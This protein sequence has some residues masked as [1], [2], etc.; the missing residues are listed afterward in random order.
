MAAM[1]A[2]QAGH[3]YGPAAPIWVRS[4]A[5]LAE[6]IVGEQLNLLLGSKP[7]PETSEGSDW[8]KFRL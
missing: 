8:V 4:R 6:G 3:Q 5:R 7:R 1:K 2:I